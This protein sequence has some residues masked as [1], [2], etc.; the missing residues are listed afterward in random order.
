MTSMNRHLRLAVFKLLRGAADA[1]MEI[2]KA[3]KPQP[4]K[5]GPRKPPKWYAEMLEVHEK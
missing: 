5:R 1:T 4:V 3:I 2:A